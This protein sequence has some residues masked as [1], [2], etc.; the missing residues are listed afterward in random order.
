M[1][2]EARALRALNY[3]YLVRAFLEVPLI[4]EPYESDSQTFNTAAAS[5]EE[6]LDFVEEDL[7]FA[8]ENA[9]ETFEN[10]NERYGRITKNAVRAL[11]A[12][13]KLWRNE[14]QACLDLCLQL[15]TQNADR[16]GDGEGKGD[17]D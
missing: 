5:E 14:Y 15:D 11:W 3:F 10:V 9:P 6:V 16:K 12:D 17:A 4:T 2:G 8:L 13:V 1:M 7:E